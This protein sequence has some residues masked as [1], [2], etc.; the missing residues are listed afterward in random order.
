M[1]RQIILLLDKTGKKKKKH[2]LNFSHQ[3]FGKCS[4]LHLTCALALA[5]S[6]KKRFWT[7][8]SVLPQ[9]SI[10][11]TTVTTTKAPAPSSTLCILVF[12]IYLTFLSPQMKNECT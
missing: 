12:C 8:G 3:D 9:L 5:S 7:K 11:K 2:S 6:A 10:T 4:G 1:F